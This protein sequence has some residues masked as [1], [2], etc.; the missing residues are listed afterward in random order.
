MIDAIR[1]GI[2]IS[3]ATSRIMNMG[4]T[5]DAR[6]YSLICLANV[7]IIADF[8]SAYLFSLRT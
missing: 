1:S 5:R 7:L 3:M 8:L 2:T 4:V 6:L